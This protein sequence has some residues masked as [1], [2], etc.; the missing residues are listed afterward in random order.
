MVENSRIHYNCYTMQHIDSAQIMNKHLIKT[1][2][3][4]YNDTLH[5]N[6]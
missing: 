3:I 2:V 5:V 6:F 4:L 1:C